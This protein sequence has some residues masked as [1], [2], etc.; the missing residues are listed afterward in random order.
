VGIYFFQIYSPK[1]TCIEK[2]YKMRDSQ[3]ETKD[4][5]E[6]FYAP[7]FVVLVYILDNILDSPVLIGSK[8]VIHIIGDLGKVQACP[9]IRVWKDLCDEVVNA[10]EIEQNGSGKGVGGLYKNEIKGLKQSCFKDNRKH[11]R[12]KNII[13]PERSTI[14][15][16]IFL[17][18]R[19]DG[20][21]TVATTND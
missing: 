20:C 21:C 19:S 2:P 7:R 5:V 17:G 15:L 1:M 4:G 6:G 3:T 12:N 9:V 11:T 16:S 14:V 10:R 18:Q 8:L 13:I